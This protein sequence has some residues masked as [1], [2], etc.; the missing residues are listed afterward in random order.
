MAKRGGEEGSG[1]IGIRRKHETLLENSGRGLVFPGRQIS[2]AQEMKPLL[3][4]DGIEPHIAL[5]LRNR[6]ERATRKQFDASQQAARRRKIRTE[7]EGG[8]GLRDGSLGIALSESDHRAD[9]V[10][11]RLARVFFDGLIGGD[12]REAERTVGLLAPLIVE[13]ENIGPGEPA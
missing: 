7:S 10:G 12:S 13:V 5:H 11:Q 4:D 9:E 6:F 3:A 1:R 2:Q 8:V